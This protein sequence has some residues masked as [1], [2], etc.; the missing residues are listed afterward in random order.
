MPL[1]VQLI[2]PSIFNL[3]VILTERRGFCPYCQLFREDDHTITQIECCQL[4]PK[5]KLKNKIGSQLHINHYTL[6]AKEVS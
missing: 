6:Y 5:E 4:E 1:S 3:G 2:K